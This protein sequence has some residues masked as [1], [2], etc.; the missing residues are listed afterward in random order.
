MTAK[1]RLQHRVHRRLAR[2]R[3]NGCDV[4]MQGVAEEVIKGL[5]LALEQLMHEKSLSWF[6]VE[7]ISG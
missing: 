1:T 3:K 6:R 5:K 4:P 7:Y 2:K